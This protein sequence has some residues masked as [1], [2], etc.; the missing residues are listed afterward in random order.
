MKTTCCIPFP[1]WLI[2][3]HCAHARRDA[4]KEKITR[5]ICCKRRL[6]WYWSAGWMSCLT[7]EQKRLNPQK[8]VQK[9]KSTNIRCAKNISK[10]KTKIYFAGERTVWQ[11][12][13]AC[14]RCVFPLGPLSPSSSCSSSLTQC[15]WPLFLSFPVLVSLCL[16]TFV[17]LPFIVSLCFFSFVFLCLSPHHT[18]LFSF[19]C[20]A[21]LFPCNAMSLH[22]ISCTW[23]YQCL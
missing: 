16:F 5:C 9:A 1:F 18:G 22:I 2:C 3:A 13:T 14:R 21:L 23:N 6:W 7:A 4:T 17:C 12:W 15:R 11:P 8:S 19:V 20:L 10:S